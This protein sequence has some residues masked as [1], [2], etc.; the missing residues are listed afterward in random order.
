[1]SRVPARIVVV[2]IGTWNLAGQWSPEHLA[3]LEQVGCD[4]WLL[5]E[6][7]VN[8]SIP[9]MHL[10]RSVERMGPNKTWAAIASTSDIA[11]FADPHRASAAAEVAGSRFVSSVLPWRSCG[12]SWAG[13]T[14]AEKL[15][16]TLKELQPTLEGTTIWGGDWNQALEGPEYVGSLEG[17]VQILGAAGALGLSIPTR[18]LSSASP[19]HRS[20]DHIAVPLAWEVQQARRVSA[21]NASRRL[22]DH[23][24]YVVSVAALRASP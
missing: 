10:H 22:S 6:V 15:A 5:T 14:L 24:A 21:S 16:T 11:P 19:G 3:L 1:M 20:I 13:D 23:D 7:H 17:R 8:L 4:V 9:G 2:R 12:P 18:S